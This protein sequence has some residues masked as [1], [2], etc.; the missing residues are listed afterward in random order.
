MQTRSFFVVEGLFYYCYADTDMNEENIN[1]IMTYIQ[2]NPDQIT[3]TLVRN[4]M[5][6]GYPLDDIKIGLGRLGLSPLSIPGYIPPVQQQN[7]EGIGITPSRTIFAIAGAAVIL[8]FVFYMGST[9][10]AKLLANVPFLGRKPQLTRPV[11]QNTNSQPTAT[12][13]PKVTTTA[14]NQGQKFQQLFNNNT[15]KITITQNN[16]ATPAPLQYYT[17]NGYIDRHDNYADMTYIVRTNSYY[18]LNNKAKTYSKIDS[19][20]FRYGVLVQSLQD[21]FLL[22]FLL[23]KLSIDKSPATWEKLSDNQWKISNFYNYPNQY[24]ISD[25]DTNGLP[26]TLTFH[27][28]TD[29]KELGSYNISFEPVIITDELLT[30]PKDYKQVEQIDP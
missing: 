16:S 22:N 26:T 3:E 27:D 7:P 14:D 29:N 25:F 17:E 13:S 10:I 18:T 12:I 2:Q 28:K 8:L 15:Y 30:V 20:D 4:L 5:N 19:T 24:I 11:E 6:V 23:N 1:N 9:N 21:A